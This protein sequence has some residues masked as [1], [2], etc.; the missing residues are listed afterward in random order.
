MAHRTYLSLFRL[1]P[2]ALALALLGA[3]ST[4][5]LGVSV[6]VGRSTG[7]G[8]SVGTDGR[9]GVGVGVS[10]GSGTVSVGTSG[11]LPVKKEEDTA[12][13]K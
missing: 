13:Q 6:P 2:P 3:C 4:A 9:V 1:A 12:E 7:V 10:V 5:N 8:V 11:Q